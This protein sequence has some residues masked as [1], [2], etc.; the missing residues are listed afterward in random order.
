MPKPRKLGLVHDDSIADKLIESD[1]QGHEPR[2]PGNAAD[3]ERFCGEANPPPIPLMAPRMENRHSGICTGARATAGR[4]V[5]SSFVLISVASLRVSMIHVAIRMSIFE[6]FRGWRKSR[7]H[8]SQRDGEIK[9]TLDCACVSMSPI[10]VS[11][12]QTFD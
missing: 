4:L 6:Q 12:S 3:I 9:L 8:H 2:Y 11:W 5:S 7:R 1:C 10:R